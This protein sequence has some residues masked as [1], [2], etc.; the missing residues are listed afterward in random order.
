MKNII[1]IAAFTALSIGLLTS[2][3]VVYAH[4]NG[5][6]SESLLK[7]DFE[8]FKS[9][10]IKNA[11]S[12]TKNLTKDQFDSMSK[13]AIKHKS[14]KKAILDS[15][16]DDFKT[17]AD[18][19]MLDQIKTLEDFNKLV[20]TSKTTKL[21]QD[22]INQS[23]KDNNFDAFKSATTELNNNHQRNLNNKENKNKQAP[24]ETMQKSRFDMLVAEYKAS[25]TLPDSNDKRG[26]EG[27]KGFN[28]K[29]GFDGHK[30]GGLK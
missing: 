13:A 23:V 29:N 10:I 22:K 17:N 14:V 24:T 12:K 30:D 20:S 4:S 26:F 8:G 11:E 25:G 7:G 3:A 19:R 27:R 9:S 6:S 21:I 16:Y 2:G 18:K 15:N 28:K 5:G 1:K